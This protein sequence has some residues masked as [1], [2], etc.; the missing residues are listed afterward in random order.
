[1]KVVDIAIEEGFASSI[2]GY[3]EDIDGSKEE[4]AWWDYI[5]L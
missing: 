4:G 1:M 5:A 3:L 2:D